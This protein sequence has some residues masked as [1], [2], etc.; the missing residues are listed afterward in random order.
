MRWQLS[1]IFFHDFDSMICYF[2]ISGIN[3]IKINKSN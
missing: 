2:I 1:I 3:V